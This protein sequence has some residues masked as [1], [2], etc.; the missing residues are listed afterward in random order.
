VRA[1]LPEGRRLERA[2]GVIYAPQTERQS[3]YFEA[4]LAAQVDAVVHL[5]ETSALEPLERTQRWVDGEAPET[6]PWGV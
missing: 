2:I 6:Y 3:H 1:Q 4:D 5:D